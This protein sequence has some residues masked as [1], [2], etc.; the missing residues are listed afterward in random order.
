MRKIIRKIYREKNIKNYYENSDEYKDIVKKW[1]EVLESKLLKE[2]EKLLKKENE[3]IYN[4]ISND[5]FD[6]LNN[7]NDFILYAY[8]KIINKK[9]SDN[10][11]ITFAT[12]YY[13]RTAAVDYAEERALSRNLY[14]IDYWDDYDCTNFVSQTLRAW[15]LGFITDWIFGKYDDDNW[16]YNNYTP[17]ESSW[18]WWWADNFYDHVLQR[19]ERYQIKS[20]YTYLS[21]WDLI[22]VDWTSNGSID[23]GMIITEKTGSTPS[24]IKLSYHS[25]DRL[26]KPLQEVFDDPSATNATY[27]YIKVIY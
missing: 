2:W 20:S 14:Y 24:L 8:Y 26:N 12:T 15:F 13:N 22:F 7:D 1:I 25:N 4:I 9:N 19:T 3:D 10:S 6:P 11:L 21:E 5:N 17:S 23:H 16:Y 27:Y 18:T